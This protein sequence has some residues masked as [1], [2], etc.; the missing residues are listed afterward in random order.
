MIS[1]N[2]KNSLLKYN[3]IFYIS[4]DFNEEYFISLEEK[5]YFFKKKLEKS[6]QDLFN[7][8]VRIKD[9]VLNDK[10]ILINIDNGDTI[11]VTKISPT[12]LEYILHRL[13]SITEFRFLE[14]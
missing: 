10:N 2:L 8:K 13:G 3:L 6:I 1:Y 9:I 5:R 11:E 12:E 4:E 7:T 14:I